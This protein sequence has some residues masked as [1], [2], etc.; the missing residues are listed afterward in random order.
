[1]VLFLAILVATAKATPALSP[2]VASFPVH[3][4]QFAVDPMRPRIYATDVA[5]NNV[6][7]FNTDSLTLE[8]TIP[9]G[10]LPSGLAISADGARL[11]VANLENVGLYTPDYIISI[12]DLESLDNLP[13]FHVQFEPSDLEEGLGNRLYVSG[14]GTTV[15]QID[16]TTGEF[17][18]YLID[19]GPVPFLLEISP[20]RRTLYAGSMTFGPEELIKFDVSLPEATILQTLNTFASGQGRI[21]LSHD[22]TFICYSIG[23]ATPGVSNPP[24]VALFTD[25]LAVKGEFTDAAFAALRLP[26][27]L[28]PDDTVA[29]EPTAEGDTSSGQDNRYH[30]AF[31]IQMRSTA[32]FRVLDSL[33]VN[34]DPPSSFASAVATDPAGRYL[35]VANYSEMVVYDVSPRIEASPLLIGLIGTPLSYQTPTTF[36]ATAFSATSLPPGLQIDNN[37]LI[38]GTPTTEGHFTT[39]LTGSRESFQI[40]QTLDFRIDRSRLKNIST[41]AY[42]R[43][44]GDTLIGGFIIEGAVPKKVVVRLLGPSLVASGVPLPPD[45]NPAYR[46]FNIQGKEVFFN[47]DWALTDGDHIT[48]LEATGLVPSDPVESAAVITLDPGAYTV[49]AEPG[50]G[51]FYHDLEGTA[52]FEVYDVDENPLSRLANISTRAFVDQSDPVIAGVIAQGPGADNVLIRGIGPSLL[53]SGILNPLPNPTLELRDSQGSLILSNDN[54]RNDQQTEIAATGI[55]PVNNLEAAIFISLA[56]GAYTAILQ[57]ANGAAGVCLVEV[58]HLP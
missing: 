54:W 15:A 30:V 13:T 7:V 49:V 25:N 44:L 26:L 20:D 2:T 19:D 31:G 42:V 12:I 55:P 57:D 24:P 6:Y 32:T 45:P 48:A 46:I 9:V 17:Q 28:S 14:P 27:A 43:I 16:S 8:K 21:T 36:D 11:F 10:G 41:R 4:T 34:I 39:T 1:M 40:S 29:Y 56:G 38:T 58:Y 5:T 33:V 3:V 53:A 22:G 37:G 23:I 47:N 35:F 51:G 52:L 18:A 50:G